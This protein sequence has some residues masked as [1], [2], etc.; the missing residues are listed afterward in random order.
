MI[1]NPNVLNVLRSSTS[2]R[3]SVE[4]KHGRIAMLATMGFLDGKKTCAAARQIDLSIIKV[5]GKCS[6]HLHHFLYHLSSVIITQKVL[7]LQFA[8]CTICTICTYPIG[9][10]TN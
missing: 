1:H 5:F 8:N 10:F 6:C 2:P 9:L 4:L 3:R 7:V